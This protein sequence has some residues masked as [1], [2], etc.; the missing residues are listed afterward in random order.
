MSITK[1]RFP[2]INNKEKDLLGVDLESFDDE[3]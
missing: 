2:K 3:Y 1:S